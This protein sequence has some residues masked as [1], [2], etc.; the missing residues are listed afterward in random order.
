MDLQYHKDKIDEL[1]LT[2]GGVEEAISRYFISYN[3][4]H[5]T[6]MIYIHN[7]LVDMVQTHARFYKMEVSQ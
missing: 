5:N 6:D 2:S 3:E 4:E 7:Y 1:L